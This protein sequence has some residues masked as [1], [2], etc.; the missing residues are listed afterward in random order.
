MNGVIRR[1]LEPLRYTPLHPQWFAF[2]DEVDWLQ[3]AAASSHGLV[4][5]VGCGRQ[6]IR[7]YLSAECQYLG[8][9]YPHT[10][11]AL[12]DTRPDVFA[13]GTR[14]PFDA[15][16]VDT[17]LALEVLEH[18]P[19]AT[20]VVAEA[21]RVLKPGGT[22]VVSVPFAYPVHDA[23][24]DFHRW[25]PMGLRTL[26]ER[27]GLAVESLEAR[28]RPLPSAVLLL[29]IALAKTA[30][31]L[32]RRRNPLVLPAF[33]ICLL[34][35]PSLNL[36]AWCLQWTSADLQFMPYTNRAVARKACR[37]A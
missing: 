1:W 20:A 35:I 5:D 29:N 34:A 26:L 31:D 36:M 8:V 33:L 18:I 30:L 21:V 16:S 15:E 22:L 12:Y 9:D 19:D 32:L 4:L 6:R 14:L 13:D 10:A 2:R 23:P 11:I 3:Q 37:P 7:R 27:P 17:V 25:T 24:Y 28:G